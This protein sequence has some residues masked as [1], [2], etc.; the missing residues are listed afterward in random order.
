M[1]HALSAGLLAFSLSFVPA[2]TDSSEAASAEG[3][4][5]SFSR[6]SQRMSDQQDLEFLVRYLIKNEK[7]DKNGK[8][9]GY[10]DV[11]DP[12]PP[13]IGLHK[14]NVDVHYALLYEDN[15][16]LKVKE[17]VIKKQLIIHTLNRKGV[18][19]MENITYRDVG[20]DGLHL[21][22]FDSVAIDDH[23]GGYLSLQFDRKEIGFYSIL[24]EDLISTPKQTERA[25]KRGIEM[26][27]QDIRR[28]AQILKNRDEGR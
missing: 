19:Y 20:A 3:I 14:K 25:Q 5:R 18:D 8:I 7:R 13:R 16:S 23:R 1:K 10:L 22:S 21:G 4:P 26:Y 17:L 28:I 27:G 11:V 6:D 12:A 9:V 2:Y 24:A 15:P